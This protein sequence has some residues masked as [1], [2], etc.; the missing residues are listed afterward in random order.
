MYALLSSFS[1]W[2]IFRSICHANE[3]FNSFVFQ[4]FSIY[5]GNSFSLFDL[6]KLSSVSRSYHCHGLIKFIPSLESRRSI[7]VVEAESNFVTDS[8][9]F[10][11]GM[12]CLDTNNNVPHLEALIKM[13]VLNGKY[14][15]LEWRNQKVQVLHQH[16]LRKTILVS[17]CSKSPCYLF[18]SHRRCI[19][20]Q[21]ANRIEV[22]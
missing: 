15:F 5:T 4:N 14:L 7:M 22:C 19:V 1:N 18:Q 13:E 9:P 12:F 10:D 6:W 11:W 17:F 21:P 20:S 8:L 3:R 16:G 2:R